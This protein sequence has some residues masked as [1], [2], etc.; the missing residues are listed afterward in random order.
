MDLLDA[1][2]D[3]GEDAAITTRQRILDAVR[4]GNWPEDP[5]AFSAIFENY[6]E[7]LFYLLAKRRG[8]QLRH[9]NEVTGSSSADNRKTPDFAAD[10]FGENYEVKTLDFSG[11]E[12]VYAKLAE[13]GRLSSAAAEAES[14]E[15]AK[16]APNG[17]GVGFSFTTFNPH[18]SDRDW[19]Q[20]MQRVMRQIGRNVKQ[21]QFKER[22]TILV[23]ALPRT[24]I[25]AGAEELQ[26]NLDDPMLGRLNGH[27][28]TLAAHRVG[29]TF[30][31]PHPDGF[32]PDPNRD[33]NDNGPL[34]QN[35]VL[36]DYA[37][38]QGIIFLH[39]IW[40][41]VD[42]ADRPN[43]NILDDAYRLHGIWNDAYEPL[44]DTPSVDPSSFF[45]VCHAFE[46]M[47]P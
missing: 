21:G 44:N 16:T 14:R 22:P 29:D 10:Q 43:A 36:R 5:N 1:A 37:F 39:T 12:H 31:W 27:L 2:A 6:H 24:S 8:V 32:Q 38:V 17:V 11:G 3:A 9:I 25:R 13:Q 47:G 40:H 18:G 45:Q 30:W 4:N 46:R 35:G 26:E 34:E 20:V 41:K 15:R 23:V 28:W 19:L 7:G 42:S 33:E